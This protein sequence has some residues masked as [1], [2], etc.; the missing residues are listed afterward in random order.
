MMNGF[1]DLLELRQRTLVE[2]LIL[3]CKENLTW[4]SEIRNQETPKV[5]AFQQQRNYKFRTVN[6]PKMVNF[7]YKLICY[8]IGTEE[9]YLIVSKNSLH[10]F[11]EAHPINL[12][13]PKVDV[14]KVF[15]LLLQIKNVEYLLKKTFKEILGYDKI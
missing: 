15:N 12:P 9:Y 2:E 13:D 7:R 4:A 5:G 11:K 6:L 1:K 10:R 14:D 3:L 8:K